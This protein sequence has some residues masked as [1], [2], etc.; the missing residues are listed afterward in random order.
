MSFSQQPYLGNKLMGSPA[1][2]S[3]SNANK[4]SE[5]QEELNICCFEGIGQASTHC[6]VT[7]KPHITTID[8][9]MMG[10]GMVS[11]LAAVVQAWT[12]WKKHQQ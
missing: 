8:W 2:N 3:S 6:P 1:G 7:P 4:S 12:A 9:V 11:A 10:A 5:N